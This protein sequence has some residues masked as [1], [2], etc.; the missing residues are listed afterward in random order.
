MKSI[1]H[2]QSNDLMV[3]VR[4]MSDFSGNDYESV[5]R[6]IKENKT[7][8][9]SLGVMFEKDNRNRV[10]FKS[11]QLNEP[12]ATFLITLMRNSDI[13]TKFKLAL[14]MEFYRMREKLCDTT[15]QQLASKDRLIE[16]KDIE[17]NEAKSFRMAT[18]KDGFMS[19]SK[20]LR[21]NNIHLGNN[22]AFEILKDKRVVEYRTVPTNELFL[23]DDS[24]GRQSGDTVIQFNS[25]FLDTIFS[26]YREM[27]KNLFSE[28]D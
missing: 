25:R 19:L 9:E 7:H 1:V 3:S 10:D 4:D 15:K 17:L 24:F 11:T 21:E 14:V 13:V 2:I 20:Y 18:Y 16:K 28:E 12:Q 8:F 27:P 5:R 26:E 23:V 22:E 6:L